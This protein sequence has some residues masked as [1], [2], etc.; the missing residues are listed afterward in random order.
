MPFESAGSDSDSAGPANRS[1]RG[2]RFR[3]TNHELSSEIRGE[4]RPECG[5][6]NIRLCDFFKDG[7]SIY[8]V[9]FHK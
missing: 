9:R 1:A 6:R 5:S 4:N 7:V 3:Q 8:P 2:C